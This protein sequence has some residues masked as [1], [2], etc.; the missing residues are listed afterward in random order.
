MDPKA[1]KGKNLSTSPYA[2]T[3]DNPI[4][5]IDPDGRDWF[6]YQAQGEKKKTWHWQ[7][8]NVAKYK[9]SKGVEVTDKKGFDYLVTYKITGKNSEGAVT[10]TLQLW[11]D[12]NPNKGALLSV[13]GAFSGNSNY[14]NTAPIPAGN[15]MMKLGNRDA[16]G[17]NRLNSET[18]PTNPQAFDGIQKIPDN[19][20]FQ[21]QGQNFTMRPTVTDAYG[22]G[23]IRLNQTDEDFNPIPLAMQPAGYYLHGKDDAIN[24]THGCVCDK[25]EALF[26]YLWNSNIKV[27]VPFSVEY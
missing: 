20:I 3:G 1:N 9:N 7:E 14:S 25:S 8:G 2:Y 18:N 15:Y 27:N 5:R 10:G 21:Y 6:N 13:P 11:G 24:W 17:P 19:A 16:D 23:R 22:N 26:N 12:R 4:S